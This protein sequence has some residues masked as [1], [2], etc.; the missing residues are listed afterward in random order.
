MDIS[1]RDAERLW[2]SIWHKENLVNKKR[3]WLMQLPSPDTNEVDLTKKKKCSSF[4]NA[5][6][7]ESFVRRD[8]V[9]SQAVKRNIECNYK[10]LYYTEEKLRDFHNYMVLSD[11]HILQ[12]FFVEPSNLMKFHFTVDLLSNN[13]LGLLANLVTKGKINFERTRPR[14]KKIIKNHFPNILSASKDG[15]LIATLHQLCEILRNS[16]NYEEKQSSLMTPACSSTLPS[17]YKAL[18]LLDSMP[19]FVLIALNRKL[20]GKMAVPRFPPSK[21]GYNKKEF[22]NKIRKICQKLILILNNENSMPEELLKAMSIIHL[23][24]KYKTKV[25]DIFTAKFFSF[26]IETVILQN[27]ILKA[28]WS[29]PKVTSYQINALQTILGVKL[30]NDSSSFLNDL[31]Q[32]LIQY[33]F[34]CDG[35]EIPSDVSNVLATLNKSSR[36]Q[37]QI[38]SNETIEVETEAIFNVSVELNQVVSNLVPCTSSDEKAAE[39]LESDDD[40]KSND[41][42]L[43]ENVYCS[44]PVKS[45]QK[46]KNDFSINDELETTGDSMPGTSF[47]SATTDRCRDVLLSETSKSINHGFVQSPLCTDCRETSLPS[48]QASKDCRDISIKELCDETSLVSYRL[49]GHMLNSFL[50][51]EGRDVGAATRQHLTGEASHSATFK[52]KIDVLNAYGENVGMKVFMH[53]LKD[54]LPSM[55][56]RCTQSVVKLIK[57]P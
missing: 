35:I 54:L 14:M 39:S 1:F 45:Q 5:F 42:E 4:S 23:Y 7:A 24:F 38:C 18:K 57:Q 13:A 37:P 33:L 52:D 17:L 49:I 10:E 31:K 15:A 8:E 48:T 40:T 55:T 36:I 20:K 44:N 22:V 28:L 46:Q 12:S 6:L 53:S 30:G 2:S 21:I 56:K 25:S 32:Y 34:E 19:I 26:S 50:L 3:R 29:I 41:F 43:V 47:I 27:D 16:K 11:L 9:S 51:V